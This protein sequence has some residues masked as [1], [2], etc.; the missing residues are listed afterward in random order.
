MQANPDRS[1][2][3][4][5]CSAIALSCAATS[6]NAELRANFIEGAPKDRFQITNESGCVLKDAEVLLDLS[7]SSAGLIFDVT[8]RGAGVEVFQPLEIVVGSA[9]LAKVPDVEDG[10]SSVR[11]EVADLS[12]GEAIAFTIDVDEVMSEKPGLEPGRGLA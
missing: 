6:V 5:L 4:L 2:L 12:P 11:L 3:F 10:Q 7:T 1:S 8:S 9:R